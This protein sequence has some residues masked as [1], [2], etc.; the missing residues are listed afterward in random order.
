MHFWTWLSI[1]LGLQ[2]KYSQTKLQN[3]MGSF[4]SCLR[5]HQLII[6]RFHYFEVDGLVNWVV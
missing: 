5:K 4:K 3:Y 1:N 6:A 2:P